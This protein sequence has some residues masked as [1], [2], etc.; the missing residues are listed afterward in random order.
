MEGCVYFFPPNHPFNSAPVRDDSRE[1]DAEINY[2]LTEAAYRRGLEAT[3]CAALLDWLPAW[4]FS[5][6]I[7]QTLVAP[8]TPDSPAHGSGLGSSV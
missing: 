8:L 2:W 5:D 1:R 3:V 6:P 4:P 7:L